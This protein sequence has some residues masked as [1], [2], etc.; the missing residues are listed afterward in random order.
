MCRLKLL[1]LHK[2]APSAGKRDAAF[3]ELLALV[4]MIRDGKARERAMAIKVLECMLDECIGP[5]SDIS[6]E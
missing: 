4:D 6:Y 1:H 5:K 3:F 2:S